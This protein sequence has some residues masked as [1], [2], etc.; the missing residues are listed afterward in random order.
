MAPSQF[1]VTLQSGVS[2]GFSTAS[3]TTT[4]NAIVTLT[5]PTEQENI[6]VQTETTGGEGTVGAQ[7]TEPR[8]KAIS[9][10]NSEEL[11][12]EL[13][14]ILKDLPTESPPGSEDI[15]GENAV[16]FWGSDDLQWKNGGPAEGGN[17]KSE[18]QATPEQKEKFKRAVEIIK[19]LSA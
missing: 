17:G 8:E 12:T 3:A 13:H 15:Y 7:S 19:Q 6:I 2:G 9:E 14:D 18:V 5:K 1:F 4:S 16:I 10:G 11:I